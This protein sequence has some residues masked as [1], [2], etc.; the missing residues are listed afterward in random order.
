MKKIYPLIILLLYTGFLLM[1]WFNSKHPSVKDIP[2]IYIAGF[3]VSLIHVI[4]S[5]NKKVSHIVGAIN[6]ILFICC[7]VYLIGIYGFL[8]S[9]FTVK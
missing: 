3:I 7:V 6:I 2:V 5:K 1:L 9:I 4:I 8:K